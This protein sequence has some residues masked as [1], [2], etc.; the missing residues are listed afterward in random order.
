MSVHTLTP[1]YY[2]THS[3]AGTDAALGPNDERLPRKRVFASSE[4]PAPPHVH[5]RRMRKWRAG[6]YDRMPPGKRK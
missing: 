6:L 2:T 1:H 5:A 3:E 4:P